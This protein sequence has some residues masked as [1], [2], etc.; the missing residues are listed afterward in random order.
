MGC[1]YN[2]LDLT[3][4]LFDYLGLEAEGAL[5]GS[6]VFGVAA[7]PSTKSTL[8]STTT[9]Q[10]PPSSTSSV[11]QYTTSN[12]TS[13]QAPTP[14]STQSSASISSPTP[15]IP[16]QEAGNIANLFLTFIQVES[17]LAIAHGS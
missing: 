17:L 5:I 1:G 9:Y 15:L 2:N 6:W 16:S 10:P 11:T 12:S 7:S 4:G 8:T 13:T 3:R 14:T